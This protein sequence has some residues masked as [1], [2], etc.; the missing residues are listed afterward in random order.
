MKVLITGANGLVG[1]A[2]IKDCQFHGDEVE[3][4][5]HKDLDISDFA[6]V[7][8][9]FRL[10]K[11]EIVL[12]CAAY[13]DVDG[14][15]SN[16][17]RCYAANSLGAENLARAARQ[18]DSAFVTISTDYVFD[19]A[20][21][22][23]YNQRDTPNPLGIYGK[24]K[25]EGEIRVRNVYARSIVVR[26]GW[27]FGN[28]GTNFLSVMHRRLYEGKT[29][30]AISDSFGTP[31]F[32]ADLARRLRELALLDIPA[33]YHVVNSGEKASYAEFAREIC[34]IKGFDESLVENVSA[35][36]LIRAAPRPQNSPL[37]C[38][39]TEKVGLR[40][41]QNWKQ[42]LRVFLYGS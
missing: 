9:I 17:E 26:S 22:G 13:T 4:C 33:V 7:E 31:T 2:A 32:A 29:I 20:K 18:I 19:G 5:T 11:P 37:S 15:E 30:K 23:F 10:E 34:L 12:N 27:I 3:A 8:E 41:L 1:R 14:S 39:L 38:L 6:R 16:A 28:F 25:L 24:A 42:A 40:P 35:D 21:N 36:S